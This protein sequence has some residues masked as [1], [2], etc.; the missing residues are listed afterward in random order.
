MYYSGP[1]W[2]TPNKGFGPPIWET[3]YISEVNGAKKVKSNSKEA[4]NKNSELRP[5]A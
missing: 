4:I 2:V 3:F 5:R 1:F